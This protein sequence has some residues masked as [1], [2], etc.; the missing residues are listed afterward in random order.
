MLIFFWLGLAV[1]VG[2]WAGNRGRNGFG[3]FLLACLI[4]PL[5][6]G[7]LL[8]VSRNLVATSQNTNEE[9]SVGIKCPK[10]AEYVSAEAIK[11][12]HCGAE[13]TPPDPIT[14]QG[15]QS[16]TSSQ[17]NSTKNVMVGIL[18]VVF[19]IGIAKII[20]T[21]SSDESSS[22]S[23]RE[24][25]DSPVKQ[26]VDRGIQYFKDI[27]SYPFLHSEPS[28]GRDAEEVARERCERTTTA[29]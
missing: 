4:S 5:L 21:L 7:A 10:C 2:V 8:A 28:K 20:D 9:N 14:L 29:F 15:L 19:I 25:S 22:V 26:C 6:A 27:G 3:W 23:A 13:L 12:K 18:A 24:A 16:R 11:C 17:E 1:V